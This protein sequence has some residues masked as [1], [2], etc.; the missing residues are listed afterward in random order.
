MGGFKEGSTP[1]STYGACGD[2]YARTLAASGPEGQPVP[3]SS[4]RRAFRT[5]LVGVIGVCALASLVFT[6]VAVSRG[7]GVQREELFGWT[8]DSLESGDGKI[9]AEEVSKQSNCALCSLLVMKIPCGR[10]LTP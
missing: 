8:K 10:G 5:G 4:R 1:Q 2:E 9:S 7:G 3:R 6:A